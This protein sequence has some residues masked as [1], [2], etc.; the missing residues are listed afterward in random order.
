MLKAAASRYSGYCKFLNFGLSVYIMIFMRL[1][2]ALLITDSVCNER[3]LLEFRNFRWLC[4]LFIPL[5]DQANVLQEEVQIY[6]IKSKGRD[7]KS[8]CEKVN[9]FEVT[10]A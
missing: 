8:A 7:E 9:I 4:I 3:Y 10:D 5:T 1:G 2:N 6:S